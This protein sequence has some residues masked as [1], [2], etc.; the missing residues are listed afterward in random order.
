MVLRSI[1][2][3]YLYVDDILCIHDD[4]DTV[5]AQIDKYIPLK[6]DSVGE[7]DV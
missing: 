2:R 4:P 3:T 6:P 1:T 5:L 7:P